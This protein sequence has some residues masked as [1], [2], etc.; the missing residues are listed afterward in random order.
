MRK[1]KMLLLSLLLLVVLGGFYAQPLLAIEEHLRV[2]IE[3]VS[4]DEAA[5]DGLTYYGTANSQW[6]STT[7]S[8]DRSGLR[9]SETQRQD[10]FFQDYADSVVQTWRSEYS[11]F[12]RGKSSFEGNYAETEENLYYAAAEDDGFL[13]ATLDKSDG[14]VSETLLAYPEKKEKTYYNINRTD[15]LDGKVIIVYSRYDE[16]SNGR[17]ADILICD[18]VSGTQEEH[19]AFD[20]PSDITGYQSV[21][22]SVLTQG[23]QKGLFVMERIEETDWEATE[24]VAPV[25][26]LSFKRY[27]WK[28]KE[29]TTLAAA[30]EVL[31][32]DLPYAIKDGIFYQLQK[33]DQ[34]WSIQPFDLMQNQASDKIRLQNTADWERSADRNWQI[35]VSDNR[36]VLT[37]NYL[38]PDQAAQLAVFELQTGEML[39]SGAITASFAGAK[40]MDMLYFDKIVYEP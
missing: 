6:K 10:A 1:Q 12:I 13:V 32:D 4:G 14:T 37:E 15:F 2:G 25:V 5:L 31:V 21:T 35:L 34:D 7:L 20:M 16:Y 36:I 39:Y 30:A 33:T 26:S 28:T 8:F 23:D 27:D 11:A 17:G 3:T 38:E 9:H 29:W 40:E 19:F 18:P 24:Y 22:T